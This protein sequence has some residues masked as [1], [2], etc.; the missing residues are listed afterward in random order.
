MNWRRKKS[1]LEDEISVIR[2][3]ATIE[4]EGHH[5]FSI[6]NGTLNGTSSPLLL[7]APLPK[8]ISSGGGASR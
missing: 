2:P 3:L 4:S 7:T 1:S 8:P 6:W 5:S